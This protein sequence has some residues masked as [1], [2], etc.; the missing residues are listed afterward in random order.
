MR[1]EGG[2]NENEQRGKRG[3]GVIQNRLIRQMPVISY[4]GGPLYT[5]WNILHDHCPIDSTD[6]NMRNIKEIPNVHERRD[7]PYFSPTRILAKPY[8]FPVF[9]SVSGTAA[10][11]ARRNIHLA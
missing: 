11:A 5:P 2:G 10:C 4:P 8:F 6:G 1:G 3:G 9:G 7:I